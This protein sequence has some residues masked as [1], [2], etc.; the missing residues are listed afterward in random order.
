MGGN[1]LVTKF[2]LLLNC[3]ELEVVTLSSTL[4]ST[5]S[6]KLNVSCVIQAQALLSSS[7]RSYLSMLTLVMLLVTLYRT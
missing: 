7:F 6:P 2:E 3:T 4:V 5:S 1:W